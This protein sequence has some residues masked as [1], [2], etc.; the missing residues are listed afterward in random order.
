MEQNKFRECPHYDNPNCPGQYRDHYGHAI[1]TTILDIDTNGKGFAGT[2]Q[3]VFMKEHGCVECM[4][5][6]RLNPP[7]TTHEV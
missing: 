3:F 5:H 4:E 6:K 1:R 2:D 7:Q